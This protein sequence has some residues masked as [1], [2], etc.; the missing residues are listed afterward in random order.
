M[1]TSKTASPKCSFCGRDK[2]EALILIAGI[3][4]HICE[5]CIEQAHEIVLEELK[6]SDTK[7]IAK[8]KFKLP[9]STTPKQIKTYLDDYII[10]QNEAKKFLSVA[11]YNHYK[12][13]RQDISSDVEI[14]KSNILFVGKT[15]TGKTLLA[16]TIARFL[17]VPFTIVDAT[18]FTEAGYVGEDVESM[19]SRLL[20]AC[21]FDVEAAQRGI[22]YI[23][24]IDKIARK[25]D[26]PSITRDVSGEGVQQAML[27]MLEG[28]EVNVP[29]QGGRKHPE[30]KLIKINTSNILFICGGAFDGLE[31]IIARRLNTQVIGFK[32]EGEEN[33]DKENIY[34]YINHQ[35]IKS[36][37]LIPELIGRLPVLTYLE[38][39]DKET[40]VRI[41]T[42]PKNSLIKQYAKLFELEGIKLE[43]KPEAYDYIAE[44]AL[45]FKLGARGLRSICEAIL[46]D[47][48]FELPSEKDVLELI[49]DKPYA[50]D[51][52]SISKLSRL[53][54][55]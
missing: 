4:G 41:L 29:P 45:E 32:K 16:K 6:H 51:K 44:K 15:G 10:G 24:E 5:I 1:S 7:S 11:V 23:D 9:D 42:E 37:G 38:P 48:M 26:N 19:L 13:L 21:D 46:T 27:K 52:L 40:L 47:A 55:A 22:V 25:N 30:Q 28:T 35:D 39:L 14:E 53:K 2:S 3:Q 36:F 34:Q 8:T 54:V 33:V 17:E 50:V 18:V 12:R 43:V 20:Q 31:K 49:I